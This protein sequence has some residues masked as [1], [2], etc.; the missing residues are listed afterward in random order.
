MTHLLSQV[1]ELISTRTSLLKWVEKL[2]KP[3]CKNASTNPPDDR[4]QPCANKTPSKIYTFKWLRGE[5][6]S[7][8]AINKFWAWEKDDVAR[9]MP[10]NIFVYKVMRSASLENTE[11]F[12]WQAMNDVWVESLLIKPELL[13][14]CIVNG[15]NFGT[16]KTT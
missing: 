9:L 15:W 4:F 8:F 5:N 2:L 12:R 3:H 10:G 13:L 1:I 14:R 16:K 6:S 11:K 7:G